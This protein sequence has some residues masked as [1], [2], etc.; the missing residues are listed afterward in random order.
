MKCKILISSAIVVAAIGGLSFLYSGLYPIG[1]DVPHTKLTYWALET[2]RERSIARASRDL[3]V[4]DLNDPSLLLAGGAD[5]NDMCALC[6][7]K[8]GKDKSDM[9]Q[10]LYPKPPNLA[11][12]TDEH[13]HSHEES[14]DQA[15]EARRRFWIIKHGIKASGMPAWGV[16][17]DDK[18]IWAMVAFLQRLPQLT[19]QQYQII[20]ARKGN[21]GMHH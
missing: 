1:A 11:K 10:G 7:L 20:T 17:H 16:T 3:Q 6:H 19:E 15:Q 12:D 2:L 21:S 13:G 4:P 18:R 14:S 9:S 5:Y 8:P